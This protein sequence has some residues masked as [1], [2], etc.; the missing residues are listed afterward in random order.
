[1]KKLFLGLCV[2]FLS[3]NICPNRLIAASATCHDVVTVFAR[4]SGAEL[5]ASDDFLEFRNSLLSS[6]TNFSGLDLVI[7]D[8][9]YP[10]VSVA[11]LFTPLGAIFD[12]SDETAS[13]YQSV[14]SGVTELQ[15]TVSSTLSACPHTSF[16]L[17]GYS[18]GAEVIST[19]IH[20]GIVPADHLIYAATFG[21]PKIYLP[22]GQHLSST[23]PAAC[24]GE[25]LSN[26]RIHVPNCYVEHGL[27]G[28]NI[29]Y[30]TTAF[31]NKIGTWCNDQ[32]LFCG[33]G[34]KL[35]GP[36]DAHLSYKT[37]GSYRQA[38]S[39]IARNLAQTFPDKVSGTV[40][41]NQAS[42][43]T[44]I[45]I[46]SSG[47]MSG[48]IERYRGEAKRLAAQTYAAGGRV[49]LYDY[50]DLSDPYDVHQLCD[51]SCTQFQ[52]EARLNSITTSGGGDD[53]ES[54]LSASLKI[55]NSLNWQRG[56]NK[57]IVILTDA[58][59]LSPDRD[60]T[61]LNAVVTRSLEI[62]PVNFYIITPP[63]N[64]TSYT[65]WAALT[66]GQIF[67][68]ADGLSLSTDY[69]TS[70]PAAALALENYF[71]APGEIF[72]FDASASSANTLDHYEWDLDLDGVF[73]YN[74][75]TN[76][77]VTHTYPAPTSGFVQVK[78]TS[79]TGESSTMSARVT[80]S[81]VASY[82]APTLSNLT[83]AVSGTTANFSFT[84]SDDTT[85]VL[86]TI[87][88][89]IVGYLTDTTFAIKNLP[90]NQELTIS[91]TP[92]S[93]SGRSGTSLSATVIS[94]DVTSPA[95][96]A[97][98]ALLKAPNAGY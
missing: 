37:D 13:Y 29:P 78:V 38:A 87:D 7:Y 97:A 82:S 66:G 76:P 2:L 42:Q 14:N 83:S 81:D 64:H 41:V 93:P 69:I 25:H 89:R 60:G 23:T 11:N 8:L 45:L 74:S 10:A 48:L 51:F 75:G 27:L 95:S 53:P 63:E 16:V 4:G 58:S 22:E 57:S 62:D 94:T 9:E 61:T 90:A 85:L 24:R 65:D 73:E 86:V 88:G 31:L 34:F 6:I 52:F 72:T 59:Y 3:I 1:M 28:A 33:A 20:Q 70:R 30:Q 91:F 50:R 79:S 17:A 36:L 92:I 96:A 71:G 55:M 26:Y 43:D 44:A 49:A 19:A 15:H 54:A 84:K 35:T 39:I 21:D 32:D 40:G 80:V 77:V 56:A 98:P 5:N 67:S 18:Q 47:S 68:S 12:L 46:D